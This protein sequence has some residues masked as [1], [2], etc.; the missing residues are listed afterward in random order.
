MPQPPEIKISPEGVV[1]K[2]EEKAVLENKS[3]YVCSIDMDGCVFNSKFY[4]LLSKIGERGKHGHELSADELEK[5]IM[6]SNP[7]LINHIVKKAEEHAE[8]ILMLGSN[9][10]TREYDINNGFK[11]V[12]EA[13]QTGSATFAIE[14]IHRI[15]QKK[16]KE[17]NLDRR[18][19]HDAYLLQD[20]YDSKKDPSQHQ[21][22]KVEYD[23]NIFKNELAKNQGQYPKKLEEGMPIEN[24]KFT[25]T[26]TQMHRIASQYPDR[27]IDY[28]LIDDLGDEILE[29]LQKLYDDYPQLKPKNTFYTFS[30]YAEKKDS[31]TDGMQMPISAPKAPQSLARFESIDDEEKHTGSIDANYHEH[32]KTVIS[33][34]SKSDKIIKK[35]L[36]FEKS[37]F[38]FALLAERAGK[39]TR[40]Y[41]GEFKHV[42]TL[43][44]KE[45]NESK[46]DII[47]DAENLRQFLNEGA[48]TE[49]DI[50]GAKKLLHLTRSLLKTPNEEVIASYREILEQDEKRPISDFWDKSKS[51]ASVIYRKS[52]NSKLDTLSDQL[53]KGNAIDDHQALIKKSALD[54][55]NCLDKEREKFNWDDFNN[56]ILLLTRVNDLFTDLNNPIYVLKNLAS[57][58]NQFNAS[59]AIQAH[60]SNLI[61]TV[62][63][64]YCLIQLES[65]AP[66]LIEDEKKVS[67]SSAIHKTAAEFVNL[68]ISA[69]STSD[70][71][72][73][74]LET[75]QST[76]DLI[77]NPMSPN[78]YE[79][80]LSYSNNSTDSFIKKTCSDYLKT[81]FTSGSEETIQ[82]INEKKGEEFDQLRGD[83]LTLIQ[84]LTRFVTTQEAEQK[85]NVDILSKSV[86]LV[87]QTQE[88]VKEPSLETEY[89]PRYGTI[90]QFYNQFSERLP[91]V[92]NNN[93][94]TF[95]KNAFQA[96]CEKHKNLL[97]EKFEGNSIM[98][99]AL[100][101]ARKLRM[102]QNFSINAFSSAVQLFVN[103][104]AYRTA[105]PN[106]KKFLIKLIYKNSIDAIKKIKQNPLSE[107]FIEKVDLD[108]FKIKLDLAHTQAQDQD[109]ASHLQ[110]ICD[111]YKQKWENNGILQTS[112][113]ALNDSIRQNINAI[114]DSEKPL[115][116]E[117]LHRTDTLVLH[118]DSKSAQDRYAKTL[119][120]INKKTPK[121]SSIVLG[122]AL[123]VLGMAFLAGA[124]ALAV[125]TFGAGSPL[126]CVVAKGAVA[127]I[128]KGL[129]IGGIIS[130]GLFGT[131]SLTLGAGSLR[132]DLKQRDHM[133]NT[134]L[135]N[136]HRFFETVKN[137]KK[138]DLQPARRQDHTVLKK[139]H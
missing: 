16:I 23:S 133:H 130:G 82:R 72:D 6:E 129:I 80:I 54:L 56:T 87:N 14:A 92:V 24:V 78:N 115:A 55:I 63:R 49:N 61:D 64:K 32:F 81:I 98:T 58:I 22:L 128:V 20:A 70:K 105:T 57:Q 10:Q 86:E 124:V 15:V 109:Q 110:Q 113:N 119:E 46:S 95:L 52:L 116:I 29:P 90:I 60:I 126:S 104:N 118:P 125:C 94:E 26:Y 121:L 103:L 89:P 44:R 135:T 139:Q 106:G 85:D 13:F 69:P 137:E 48:L 5:I 73:K 40:D 107:Q 79:T 4:D 93:I 101:L 19:I 41:L 12:R 99:V 33:I 7:E 30:Q 131:T 134:Y 68:I 66:Q 83:A 31:K 74:K 38:A 59:P 42:S 91:A 62:I 11:K 35:G 97:A 117:L 27:S 21:A 34:D 28:E 96:A 123:V 65:K 47:R 102:H 3:I 43:C 76:L 77:S 67:S 8:T 2:K 127:T 25:I 36:S 75:I 17:K 9:R 114:P 138:E 108:N 88:L 45:W 122:A 100:D 37:E 1:E 18:I 50:L 51:L 111:E 136:A 120:K 112:A 71:W 39:K 84:S 53:K 132:H